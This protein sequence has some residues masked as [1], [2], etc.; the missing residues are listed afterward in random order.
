MLLTHAEFA[1]FTA[2]AIA[3]ADRSCEIPICLL[4]ESRAAVDTTVEAAA[5]DGTVDPGAI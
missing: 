3:D 4:V 1:V 2:K 5:R